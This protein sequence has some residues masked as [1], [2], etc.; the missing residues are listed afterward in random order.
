[1]DKFSI[2]LQT[3]YR[4][5]GIFIQ[6][7]QPGFVVS[8]M[9]KIRK[10]S[11]MAP[12]A[13]TYVCSALN[14]LGISERTAGYWPHSILQAVIGAMSSLGSPQWASQFV[15]KKLLQMRKKARLA[16][17]APKNK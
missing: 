6:S 1:M 7:V 15:F 5:F 16:R 10:P 8:N 9:T 13:K 2:D 4:P 14:T 17:I 3:E 12:A 11:L